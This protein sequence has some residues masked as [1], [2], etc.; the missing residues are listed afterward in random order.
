MLQKLIKLLFCKFPHIEKFS[1]Q[2]NENHIYNNKSS[3][4][5]MKK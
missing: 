5:E 1:R 4:M 3:K 2:S